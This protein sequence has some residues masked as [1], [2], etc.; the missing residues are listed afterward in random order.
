VGRAGET[1]VLFDVFVLAQRTRGLLD[2]ALAGAPLTAAQYAAYSAV[3][4]FG[5]LSTSDLARHLGLPVSSVHE[6]VAAMV[7]R[8]HVERRRDPRDGR[9]FLLR[10]TAAGREQHRVTS[11]FFEVA[12][13]AVEDRLETPVQDVRD[14]LVELTWA[15]RGATADVTF[16]A[17]S[18]AG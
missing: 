5:P 17:S 3:L 1:S 15:C 7:V 9:A 8:G 2:I 12:V 14:A 11:R 10:L 4:E 6:E 18:A 13:R 16:D